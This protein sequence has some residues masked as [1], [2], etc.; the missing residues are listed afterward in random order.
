M[1]M[2]MAIATVRDAVLPSTAQAL[3][4]YNKS[5]AQH[6]TSTVQALRKHNHKH[7]HNHNHKSN[8]SAHKK[9]SPHGLLASHLL[10]GGIYPSLGNFA[11]AV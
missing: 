6:S 5:T 11:Q 10:L 4:K 3:R 2:E 1:A 8:H 9:S 7:K